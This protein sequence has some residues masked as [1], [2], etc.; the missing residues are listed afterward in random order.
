ML[1]EIERHSGHADLL[2]EAID[3]RT[4]YDLIAEDQGIDMSYIGAWFADH[5]EIPAPAW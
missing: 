4:M 3:G 1:A 5:P 2:R